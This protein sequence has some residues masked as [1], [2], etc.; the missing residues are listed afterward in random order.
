VSDWF[1]VEH[2]LEYEVRFVSP[3]FLGD[4]L[5]LS[6]VVTGLDET[7]GRRVAT[8]EL[9]A[10]RDDDTVIKGTAKAVVITH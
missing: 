4:V 10:T 1:G 7:D 2:L 3:V 8:V 6:G 9:R 5:T